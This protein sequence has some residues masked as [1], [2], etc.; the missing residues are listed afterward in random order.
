MF[1]G[2]MGMPRFPTVS[3]AL[4]CLLI[5]A[6]SFELS[7]W[8]FTLSFVVLVAPGIEPGA[9]SMLGKCANTDLDLQPGWVLSHTL[10]QCWF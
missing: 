5:P 7:V 9:L 1:S 8:F 10:S 3:S 6:L 2:G 4:Y